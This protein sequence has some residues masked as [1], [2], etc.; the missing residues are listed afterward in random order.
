MPLFI[1]KKFLFLGKLRY[2]DISRTSGVL[3]RPLER[4]TELYGVQYMKKRSQV[5]SDTKLIF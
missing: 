3:S 4:S 5:E 2:S 1:C